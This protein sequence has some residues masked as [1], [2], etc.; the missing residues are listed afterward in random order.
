MSLFCWCH[1][2]RFAHGSC[3][4]AAVVALDSKKKMYERGWEKFDQFHR[5]E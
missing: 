5:A 4:E 1:S 3:A 2:A